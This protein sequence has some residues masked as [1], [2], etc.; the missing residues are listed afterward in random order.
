MEIEKIKTNWISNFEKDVYV[1]KGESYNL[2]LIF[3]DYKSQKF[4][5]SCVGITSD[6]SG[7]LVTFTNIFDNAFESFLWMEAKLY[8]SGF[9]Y[10]E[11]PNLYKLKERYQEKF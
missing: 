8:A 2:G 1:R 3:Y 4:I 11:I 7:Q 5:A 10:S 6:G 9:Q